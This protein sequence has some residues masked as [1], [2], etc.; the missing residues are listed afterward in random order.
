MAVL[1][2]ALVDN[3]S[4]SRTVLADVD[5]PNALDNDKWEWYGVGADRDDGNP[6]LTRSG[7]IKNSWPHVYKDPKNFPTQREFKV[8]PIGASMQLHDADAPNQADSKDR[9]YNAGAQRD[10]QYARMS[11]ADKAMAAGMPQWSP[12]P[13]EFPIHPE[14]RVV[15]L[16]TGMQLHD[17]DAPNALDAKDRFYAAGAQRDDQYTRVPYE[18]RVIAGALPKWSPNPTE[19][20]IHAEFKPMRGQQMLARMMLPEEGMRVFRGTGE[21]MVIEAGARAGQTLPDEGVEGGWG[22]PAGQWN[23]AASMY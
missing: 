20:P 11:T 18:S 9:F 1:M 23:P 2:V 17:A 10:D 12:N 3:D 6:H 4:S 13:T 21:T 5:G 8:V 19:F 15:P 14:F 7:V 16:G 22:V